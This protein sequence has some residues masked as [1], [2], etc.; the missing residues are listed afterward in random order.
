[1]TAEER[2]DDALEEERTL[3]ELLTD[4]QAAMA[5]LFQLRAQAL[6][7]SRM[8]WR[9]AGAI[10]RRPGQTQRELSDWLGIAPS[11]IGKIIDHLE[12]EQLVERRADATDRRINR[13][14]PTDA[15]KPLV[16]PAKEISERLEADVLNDLP[17]GA[18]MKRRLGQLKGRLEALAAAEL[19][20]RSAGD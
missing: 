9:V 2:I 7:M 18:R 11:P 6:G 1:M 3:L 8:Q 5:R 14:Y 19:A 16:T 10:N 12:A 13:L 20:D 17:G 4:A 15:I